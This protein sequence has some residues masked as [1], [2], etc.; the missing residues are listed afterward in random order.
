MGSRFTGELG[1]DGDNLQVAVLEVNWLC[2]VQEDANN[3]LPHTTCAGP[4]CGLELRPLTIF[5]LSLY[6]EVLHPSKLL[7]I[8]TT[9]DDFAH[10]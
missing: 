1:S 2:Q 8:A 9:V 5:L 3:F 6:T 10:K 7:Q 4:G